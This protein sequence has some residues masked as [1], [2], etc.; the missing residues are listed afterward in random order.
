LARAAAPARVINLT[1][2][3]V[4]GNDL[5]T[6][7]SGPFVPDHSIFREVAA[8]LA[9]YGLTKRIPSSVQHYVEQGQQGQIR[10][11]PKPGDP[12]FQK[13]INLV[14]ASNYQALLAAAS[15]AKRKG[16]RPLILSSFIVGETK[17]VAKVHAALAKEVRASGHPARPPAC[18]I[19]GGET[20][21]TLKGN[22]KGGRNQEFALAAA[23]ELDGMKDVLLF[24]GGTDGADGDT[25]AAGAM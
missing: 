8:I 25:E 22:G 10:E 11:T 15:E 4:V 6:I 13:V 7:A 21:V 23:I 19:S 9:R 16:Y 1:L 24:S 20:T 2:S 17:E 3:D 5:D 12:V 14:V 18:L